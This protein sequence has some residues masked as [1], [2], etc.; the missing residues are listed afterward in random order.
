MNKRNT[1][2]K[3]Q[4]H[5]FPVRTPCRNTWCTRFVR[6]CRSGCVKVIA[7]TSTLGLGKCTRRRRWRK[8]MLSRQRELDSVGLSNKRWAHLDY[9]RGRSQLHNFIVAGRILMLATVKQQRQGEYHEQQ[10][11]FHRKIS[12][13]CKLIE[14]TQS[15]WK[16][17]RWFKLYVK[18]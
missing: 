4:N 12:N 13:L 16:P 17:L 6:S 10:Y 1:P 14:P 2:P 9:Y 3:F 11:F 18:A 7:A 5:L 15:R 8:W